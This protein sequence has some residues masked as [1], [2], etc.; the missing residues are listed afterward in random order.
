MSASQFSIQADLA[1]EP[2]TCEFLFCVVGVRG[3]CGEGECSCGIR[4]EEKRMKKSRESIRVNFFFFFFTPGLDEG[5]QK[6][7]C[8]SPGLDGCGCS[9][10]INAK[11]RELA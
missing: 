8:L 1:R 4:M 6:K 2:L 3:S 9:S 11:G 7:R 5:Q 10:D